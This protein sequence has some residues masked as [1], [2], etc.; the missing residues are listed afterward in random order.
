MHK[1]VSD[2][3]F[4]SDLIGLRGGLWN[5]KDINGGNIDQTN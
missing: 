3:Q 2:I 1:W 5:T 4:E